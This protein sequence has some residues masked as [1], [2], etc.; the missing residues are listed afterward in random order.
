MTTHKL[1]KSALISMSIVLCACTIY[2]SA[3][4]VIPTNT[5]DHKTSLVELRLGSPNDFEPIKVE[6]NGS[7]VEIRQG[8]I[9]GVVSGSNSNTVASPNGT[10]AGGKRNS[11]G[12]NAMNSTIGAGEQNVVNAP[13]SVI[14]AGLINQIHQSAKNSFI[15]G[16]TQ[17]TINNE[18]SSIAGGE[19]NEISADNAVV[20]GNENTILASATNSIA[21]GQKNKIGKSGTF[22]W[23]DY[24]NTQYKLMQNKEF[25][26]PQNTNTFLVRSKNGMGINK[27]EAPSGVNV[28]IE[29]SVQIH[30]EGLIGTSN[31]IGGTF[32]TDEGCYYYYDGKYWQL[33]N[34]A[35]KDGV[36]P[37]LEG[38]CSKAEKRCE[39]GP[40]GNGDFIYLRAGDSTT[41][42][43][44]QTSSSCTSAVV[45]CGANG[46]LSPSG[47]TFANCLPS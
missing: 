33:L 8:L 31:T 44:A 4:L 19:N 2:A 30:K 35:F 45:T 27:N 29:G 37:V 6:A 26:E 3:Q 39:I 38:K 18:N 17:N 16:G 5:A 14:G 32:E 47:Y 24:D 23:S 41:A 21:L 46:T 36:G 34:A 7:A 15:G 12:A 20:L 40:V 13:N 10:I 25:L 42:Y 28:A 1:A 22:A 43:N 9:A 11:I